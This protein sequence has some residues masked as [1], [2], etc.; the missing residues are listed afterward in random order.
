SRR[1]HT[2]WP[3]DWSSDVCSSDLLPRDP[4]REAPHL[5]LA[6]LGGRI[7]E[8][9]ELV[10]AAELDRAE[11]RMVERVPIDVALAAEL[12]IAPANELEIVLGRMLA[13]PVD[14]VVALDARLLDRRPDLHRP[15]ELP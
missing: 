4:A 13:I 5:A 14:E 12:A 8:D 3:R 11:L 9:R 15:D 6:I 10:P 1:R 2:R 7:A